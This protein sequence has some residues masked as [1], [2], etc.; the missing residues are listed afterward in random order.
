MINLFKSFLV[1]KTGLYSNI[2]CLLIEYFRLQ[3]LISRDSKTFES[4]VRSMNECGVAKISDFMQAI[5][6]QFDKPDVKEAQQL[7]NGKK[8]LVNI[9]FMLFNASKT[10]MMP[11]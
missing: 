5:K 3:G 11:P 1:A 7:L 4:F 8:D 6:A 10:V 2:Y 9:M